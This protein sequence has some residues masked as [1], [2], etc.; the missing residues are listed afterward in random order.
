MVADGAYL[1]LELVIASIFFVEEEAEVFDLLSAGH[2]A[3]LV[4]VVAVVVVVVLHQF[5]ILEVAVLLLD[6]VELVAEGD[7]VLV[8]LLN[9][10]DLGLK[11]A[12]EQVLL[13][14]RQVHGVVVLRG[15][16]RF[17]TYFS[18]CV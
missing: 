3:D 17:V 11:L 13:V 5:F 2:G 8:S 14:A 4:L 9:F 7:I 6:G 15:S 1:C 16:A 10:E 18:H 12:D